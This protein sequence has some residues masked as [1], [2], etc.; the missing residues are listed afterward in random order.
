[1]CEDRPTTGAGSVRKQELDFECA[2]LEVTVSHW[3]TKSFLEYVSQVQERGLDQR[4][5]RKPSVFLSKKRKKQHG[6]LTALCRQSWEI[7]AQSS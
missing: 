3:E 1:M 5:N 7:L 6:E 2:A 4:R